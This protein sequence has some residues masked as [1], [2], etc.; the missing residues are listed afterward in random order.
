[1]GATA[2]QV[3]V[4]DRLGGPFLALVELLGPVGLHPQE[5]RKREAKPAD[6]SHVQEFSTGR[7]FAK[8]PRVVMPSAGDGLLHALVLPGKQKVGSYILVRLARTGVSHLHV[9]AGW[10]GSLPNRKFSPDLP[11]PRF[12]YI[13]EHMIGD[14]G[15][16]ARNRVPSEK[17]M[18]HLVLVHS[19]STLPFRRLFS[20]LVRIRSWS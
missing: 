14:L 11:T 9:Q 17:L 7:L 12:F 3:D 18:C 20:L 19:R 10:G 13:H 4:D 16:Q 15:C 1:M 5:F 8:M 6:Q 2:W